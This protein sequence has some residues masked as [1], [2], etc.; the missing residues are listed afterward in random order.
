MQKRKL[1]DLCDIHRGKSIETI[2]NGT[3]PIFYIAGENGRTDHTICDK[4][5][6]AIGV[7]GTIGKPRL[8]YPPYWINGTQIF[9]TAKD[10]VDITFLF[11]VFDNMDFSLYE[12]KFSIRG[13]FDLFRFTNTEI[14]YTNI[15]N[16]KKIGK[17]YLNILQQMERERQA[18]DRIKR[19]KTAMLDGMFPPA[20]VS[21]KEYSDD[22]D[23]G[24][25]E[26][27]NDVS[28]VQM[29]LF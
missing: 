14:E 8:Y 1:I 7:Q 6:V 20:D 13:A 17:Y 4:P 26:I 25:L 11:A 22:D 12:D 15:E 23:T 19:Y 24:P 10:D 21:H 9:I 2:A 5:C 27:T 29:D 18:I 28:F 3:V 16:Q